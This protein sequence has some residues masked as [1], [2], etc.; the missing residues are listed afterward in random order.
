MVISV[1]NTF[2]WPKKPFK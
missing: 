1:S 2:V